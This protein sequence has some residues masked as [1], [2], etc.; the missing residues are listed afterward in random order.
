MGSVRAYPSLLN[1][2]HK[3][4]SV[5]AMRLHLLLRAMD[6]Q[7]RGC[8][9]VHH[10]RKMLT[11]RSRFRVKQSWRR[12]RQIL[13]D[14]DGVYWTRDNVGRIWLR[15]PA[16]IATALDCDH[17]AGRPILLKLAD[18]R[19]D[20]ATVKAHFFA[21]F[22]SGRKSPNP[23]S[24]AALADI[25]GVPE[26]TQREYNR[27]LDR[28]ARTNVAVTELPWEPEIFQPMADKGRAVFRFTDFHGVRGKKGNKYVAYRV[29]DS[30]SLSHRQG[31]HGR[32]AKINRSINLVN[33][34][35]RG[36][37]ERLAKRYHE[38][39]AAAGLAYGKHPIDHYWPE[40]QTGMLP[41]ARRPALIEPVALWGVI[42]GVK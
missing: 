15:A 32:Q 38:S 14:G 31:C 17:L 20:I 41:N 11:T 36:N 5:P 28:T 40:K 39:Q 13:N 18:L 3:A 21:A 35:Q 26:R 23:I 22:E 34:P 16:R 19:K 4:G 8:V 33:N 25:T 7:G 10:A 24:Q 37:S 30:R 1:A 27:I 9:H 2:S 29:P 42:I 12:I 6:D